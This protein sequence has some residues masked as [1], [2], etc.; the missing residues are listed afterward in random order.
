LVHHIPLRICQDPNP[1]ALW[2]ASWA[3]P[4]AL[5]EPKSTHSKLKR[6]QRRPLAIGNP[7]RIAWGI[8]LLKG[9]SWIIIGDINGL[10]LIG[11]LNLGCIILAFI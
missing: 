3:A 5:P 11:H 4:D 10:L 1:E 9:I 6:Q 8:W 2:A 7:G